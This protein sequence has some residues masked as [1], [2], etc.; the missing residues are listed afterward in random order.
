MKAKTEEFLYLL[1][2]AGETLLRPN[3]R[4]MTG[5]FE[6]WAYRNGL[7]RQLAVLEKQQL[8]ESLGERHIERVHRLTET[9]RLIALGGRD[10]VARWKRKWDG[11]WRMVLYDV[12][13]TQASLRATLRRSLAE[14]GFGYLQNSVWI[15]PD[16]LI[17]ERERLMKDPVDVGSLI[18]IEARTCA[19]ESDHEIVG[20][21]W[22]FEAIN[23]AYDRHAAVLTLRPKQGLSLEGAAKSFHRWLEE[24]RLA[25]NQALALDPL[26]PECLHPPN[27]GGVKAWKQRLEAQNKA[28]QQLRSFRAAP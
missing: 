1:L 7:M 16:P 20:K 17:G 3:F 19:G 28:G 22:N 10:P 13:Q 14:R 23:E 25:W 12:P 2:W 27:Y 24:E 6:E 15:T 8:L 21:A 4:N 9:G 11:N 5:S 18:L 26:L